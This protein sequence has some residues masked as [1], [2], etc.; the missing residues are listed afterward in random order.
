MN[1]LGTTYNNLGK[2]RDSELLFEKVLQIVQR[3]LG[4]ENVPYLPYYRC[5]LA[6]V[7]WL[8][9]RYDEAGRLFVEML[10]NAE[11]PE[12]YG[13]WWELQYTYQLGNVYICLLY[14]SPSPRD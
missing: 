3:E 1:A 14:T 9:G 6:E 4:E 13:K 12:T 5:N 11:W 10:E 7:Y 8:Q 2:Y